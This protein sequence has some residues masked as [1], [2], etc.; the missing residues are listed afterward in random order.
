[1]DEPTCEL[2]SEQVHEQADGYGVSQS[3]IRL[4]HSC[5][6]VFRC[7]THA[8]I[9]S[10]IPSIIRTFRCWCVRSFVHQFKHSF[11]CA[12]VRSSARPLIRLFVHASLHQ[13]THRFIH[14]PPH[15]IFHAQL[16]LSYLCLLILSSA[17]RLIFEGLCAH[18][19]LDPLAVGEQA[20]CCCCQL[21][22]CCKGSRT[23]S[24][25]DPSPDNV[26]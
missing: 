7:S 26:R 25:Q 14:S 8:F 17:C 10:C 3:V 15:L 20:W 12:F 5:H 13:F 9:C 6:S 16:D 1:M 11:A 21:P 18:V 22:S 4:F 19:F 24:C 23:E 2:T